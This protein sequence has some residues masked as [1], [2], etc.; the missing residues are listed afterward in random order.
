MFQAVLVDAVA[1]HALTLPQPVVSRGQQVL[2]CR[3]QDPA[4]AANYD[5]GEVVET[6]STRMIDLCS[7]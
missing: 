2:E 5:D 7:V 1:E 3:L 6:L 4:I